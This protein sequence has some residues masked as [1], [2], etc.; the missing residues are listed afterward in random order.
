MIRPHAVFYR[1]TAEGLTAY[2][3]C[4]K[5]GHA[6][7]DAKEAAAL[8]LRDKQVVA[9][10]IVD[11]ALPFEPGNI[12][13]DRE[14]KNALFFYGVPQK[15]GLAT[16]VVKTRTGSERPLRPGSSVIAEDGTMAMKITASGRL[17]DSF[18]AQCA[19]LDVHPA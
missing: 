1:E 10:E 18:C 7:S 3:P 15:D 9:C 6:L 16:P 2:S 12:T 4:T 13:L 14:T 19:L 5:K 8:A 11:Q 17:I